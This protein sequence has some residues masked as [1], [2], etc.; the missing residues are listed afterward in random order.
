[1]YKLIYYSG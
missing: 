1:M